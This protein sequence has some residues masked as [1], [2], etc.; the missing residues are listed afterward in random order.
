MNLAMASCLRPCSYNETL[1]AIE[2]VG[3]ILLGRSINGRLSVWWAT[4]TAS[5]TSTVGEECGRV[6]KVIVLILDLARPILRE[7]VFDAATD[8][9]AI[10]AY[11][12]V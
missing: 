8:G 5:E 4:G 10:A 3:V 9:V 1:A 12:I 7:Q 11:V 6:A 2:T